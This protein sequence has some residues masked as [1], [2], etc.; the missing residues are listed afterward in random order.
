[1]LFIIDFSASLR[2]FL[3]VVVLDSGDLLAR[4]EP[5]HW[6][7]QIKRAY[8]MRARSTHTVKQ[9]REKKQKGQLVSGNVKP[10]IDL[11]LNPLP[12]QDY[13][14][15]H[16]QTH[17]LCTEVRVLIDSYCRLEMKLAPNIAYKAS[18]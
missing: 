15:T 16:T 1:M 5:M 4:N 18:I 14:H 11:Q 3:T 8:K 2:F 9:Q 17:T 7:F 10:R 13:T 12:N 6:E